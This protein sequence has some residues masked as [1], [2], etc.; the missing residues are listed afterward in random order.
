[1]GTEASGC[2]SVDYNTSGSPRSS[3]LLIGGKYFDITQESYGCTYSV[4]PTSQSVPATGASG[5]VSVTVSNGC[6][7]TAASSAGWI[8]VNSGA[9]GSGSGQVT[10]TVAANSGTT[11]RT[12]ALTVAGKTVT[13]N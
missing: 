7:W 5:S 4:S 8:I 1:M 10:Y 9:S 2:Y 12:G 11:S 6:T 3:Y 13:I